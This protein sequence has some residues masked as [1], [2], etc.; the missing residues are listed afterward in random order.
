MASAVFCTQPLV[1]LLL[2]AVTRGMGFAP[3]SAATGGG[4]VV[5][6]RGIGAATRPAWTRSRSPAVVGARLQRGPPVDSVPPQVSQPVQPPLQLGDHAA[7]LPGLERID[8]QL[9]LGL[10]GYGGTL[11]NHD[12]ADLRLTLQDPDPPFEVD[13]P[14]PDVLGDARSWRFVRAVSTWR[15][16]TGSPVWWPSV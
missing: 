10:G 16:S 11:A 3:S 1:P 12:L 5:G 13:D 9:L 2:S 4:R 6:P 8:V 15:S 7:Q 14:S